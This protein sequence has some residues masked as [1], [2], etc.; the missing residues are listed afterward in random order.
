MAVGFNYERIDSGDTITVIFGDSTPD[1]SGTFREYLN[2]GGTVALTTPAGENDPNL[3]QVHHI[4]AFDRLYKGIPPAGASIDSGGLVGEN[5]KVTYGTSGQANIT[6]LV[7]AVDRTQSLL[8]LD[9]GG[10][11]TIVPLT[12]V[13]HIEVL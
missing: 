1:L 11:V 7:V 5:V 12:Q 13:W 2:D 6:G 10:T 3:Y 4:L 9:V 8:Q